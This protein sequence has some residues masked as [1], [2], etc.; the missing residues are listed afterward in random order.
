MRVR[1]KLKPGQL[2]TKHLSRQY[3]RW[4]KST[5]T[6]MLPYKTARKLGLRKR[7]VLEDDE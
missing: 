3:D 2:G 1:L 7:I 6:W 5:K 4:S